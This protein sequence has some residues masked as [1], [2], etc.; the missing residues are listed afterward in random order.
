MLDLSSIFFFIYLLLRLYRK[1]IIERYKLL[2]IYLKNVW[3]N[4]AKN[5]AVDDISEAN[6]SMVESDLETKEK[7]SRITNCDIFF[8]CIQWI[9]L[10]SFFLICSGNL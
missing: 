2:I 6:I 1:L 5:E 9:R 8:F 4:S 7:R 3:N 10:A